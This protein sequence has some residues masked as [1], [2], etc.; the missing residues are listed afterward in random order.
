MRIPSYLQFAIACFTAS[1]LHA[2]DADKAGPRI[3]FAETVYDFGKVK[4]GE[5]V[6]HSFVFTNTG[7]ATL[8]IIEVKPGCG[9]T[10]AG[11]WD[12]MIEPGKT[13][14]IPLQFNSAGFGGAVSKSATVKCNDA[15][16]SN[17]VLQLNGTVWKPIDLTHATAFFNF[18]A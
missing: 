17:V 4:G 13:G 8:E 10:T 5:V 11:T 2:V 18:P 16:R 6:K 14:S 15:A 3:Q 7:S 12:K 9:C 1:F